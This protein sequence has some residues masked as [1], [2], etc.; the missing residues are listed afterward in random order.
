MFGLS[1]LIPPSLGLQIVCKMLSDELK[2][3][4]HK[5][6]IIYNGSQDRIDFRVFDVVTDK[7]SMYSFPQGK[8]LVSHIKKLAATDLKTG[9]RL[10]IAI[11]T[12]TKTGD[13]VDIY[14]TDNDNKKTVINHKL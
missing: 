5:Y 3:P 8:M 2:K 12:H 10:D 6:Q 13:Q 4:V 1:S 7:H 9:E 11:I 14:F